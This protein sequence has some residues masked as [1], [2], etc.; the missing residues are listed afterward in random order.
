MLGGGVPSKKREAR[1]KREKKRR[2]W[3]IDT[4]IVRGVAMRTH[5]EQSAPGLQVKDQT[6]WLGS[7]QP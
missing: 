3:R 7:P 4:Q 5:R 2:T 6:M 1:K